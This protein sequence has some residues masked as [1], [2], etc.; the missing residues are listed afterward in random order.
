MPSSA[1]FGE[2]YLV[3]SLAGEIAFV[4]GDPERPVETAGKDDH[5]DGP[6]P[7]GVTSGEQAFRV[8]SI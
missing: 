1:F 7:Q 8:F 6:T 3:P 2:P 5:T 4:L